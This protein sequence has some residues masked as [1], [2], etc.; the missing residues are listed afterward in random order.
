MT[1]KQEKTFEYTSHLNK[2]YYPSMLIYCSSDYILFLESDGYY[3]FSYTKADVTFQTNID[4]NEE[5][6]EFT[7]EQV[8]YAEI[9]VL[10]LY[11]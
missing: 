4:K 5:T 2:A 7:S 9:H 8:A 3:C 1:E 6:D 11:I 10:G